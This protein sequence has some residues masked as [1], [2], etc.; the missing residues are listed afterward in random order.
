M[1]HESRRGRQYYKAIWE[2]D[3]QHILTFYMHAADPLDLVQA[4]EA[5]LREHPEHEIAGRAGATVR[6]ELVYS[7]RDGDMPNA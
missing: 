6:F 2:R 7:D 4:A 5:F 1:E 3:G